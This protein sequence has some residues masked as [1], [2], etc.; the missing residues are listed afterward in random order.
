[1]RHATI[2]IKRRERIRWKKEE[3]DDE[4]A[5]K[6]RIA[7][8]SKKHREG[9]TERNASLLSEV[10]RYKE[11]NN[12]NT[13]CDTTRLLF[14]DYLI[15]FQ[16]RTDGCDTYVYFEA[17]KKFW[18]SWFDIDKVLA[19]ETSRPIEVVR[20]I[21]REVWGERAHLLWLNRMPQFM[22][23]LRKALT[24][25]WDGTQGL[26][27]NRKVRRRGGRIPLPRVVV[28]RGEVT[29]KGIEVFWDRVRMG[30]IFNSQNKSIASLEK[31]WRE[32]KMRKEVGRQWEEMGFLLTEET[33]VLYTTGCD[34]GAKSE[35]IV[36]N[37]LGRIRSA[38]IDVWCE[39][40]SRPCKSLVYLGFLPNRS[41]RG[42]SFLLKQWEEGYYLGDELVSLCRG[43]GIPLNDGFSLAF[44]GILV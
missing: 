25:E 44:K 39:I 2:L 11:L 14:R 4:M 35:N 34:D 5:N 36:F 33:I 19:L 38:G 7:S 8:L 31:D 16:S 6:R 28:L 9:E 10:L 1:M 27:V 32:G 37:L 18:V 29:S 17:G 42:K 13:P 41:K 3:E 40:P 23:A 30:F 20:D 21:L 24:D 12:K 22:G 43:G 15:S 26:T